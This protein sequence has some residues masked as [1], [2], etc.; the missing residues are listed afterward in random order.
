GA[1]QDI[2]GTL[3]V[4]RPLAELE[5]VH[6]FFPAAKGVEDRMVEVLQGLVA[7]NLDDAGH[8]RILP[9]ELRGDRAAEQEDLQ[10]VEAHALIGGSALFRGRFL[11]PCHRRSP[12]DPYRAFTRES[13]RV[14]AAPCA[15]LTGSIMAERVPKVRAHL[16][17]VARDQI[18]ISTA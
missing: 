16:G 14:P 15:D 18:W 13:P 3:R 7:P 2:P 6:V 11:D 5:L 10:G 17:G 1:R 9:C 4:H 12:A 8:H